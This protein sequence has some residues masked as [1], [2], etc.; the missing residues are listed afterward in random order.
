MTN[1]PQK[2]INCLIVEDEPLSQEILESYIANCQELKLCGT[3]KDAMRANAILHRE[4]IDLIFLDINMPIINGIEWLKS[5]DQGPEV[6]FTTA[7]PEHAV[8]GFDLNAL[9]YL[10]KPFSFNR[11]L[12][13][14]NKFLVLKKNEEVNP[15]GNS[16]TSKTIWVKSNKK[17]YPIK[18]SELAYIESDGD[19]LKLFLGEKPI[20]IH[21]TLKNFISKL[22]NKVFMKI[23]RSFVININKVEY[24]EGNQVCLAS[25]LIPVA[26]SY[27]EEFYEAIEKNEQV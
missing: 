21:E 22:P 10:L 2:Y 8:E 19:Y 7:Y 3:C 14:V 11:F 18:L 27:R 9:D 12:K 4:N 26:A 25:K 23:H 17:S 16:D 24:L 1:T 5:L 20:I 13:A 6:I 15:I